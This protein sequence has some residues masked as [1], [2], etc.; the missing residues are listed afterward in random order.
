MWFLF[1]SLVIFA[2]VASN[3][4][5]H[6]TPN[7]YLASLLGAGLAWVLTQIINELPQSLDGLRRRGRIDR[8]DAE[9]SVSRAK[10]RD[11]TIFPLRETVP[12]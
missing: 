1:Q 3:I 7:A 11:E 2:V 4:H 8:Q 5:W 10:A 12:K 9:A 6:W